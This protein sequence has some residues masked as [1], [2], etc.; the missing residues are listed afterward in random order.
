MPRVAVITRELFG[1][2]PVSLLVV[3]GF[4]AV[5]ATR[6][7]S[8]EAELARQRKLYDAFD[9]KANP[10][11]V[12][13]AMIADQ[14]RAAELNRREAPADADRI[15][16]D[17]RRRAGLP[18]QGRHLDAEDDRAHHLGPEPGG[19]KSGSSSGPRAPGLRP[20]P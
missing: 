18:A 16:D 8:A 6:G 1:L 14:E 2:I 10:D 13:D 9:F 7:R 12:L 15:I 17:A 20:Q 5:L 11:R 4:A 19:Q 3:A